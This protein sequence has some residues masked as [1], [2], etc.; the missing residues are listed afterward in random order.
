MHG[1]L[2]KLTARALICAFLIA[3]S[4]LSSAAL[5][6]RLSVDLVTDFTPVQD[7]YVVRVS[8]KRVRFNGTGPDVAEVFSERVRYVPFFEG[9]DPETSKRLGDFLYEDV[10]SPQ[11]FLVDVDLL[12]HQENIVAH[13]QM[14]VIVSDGFTVTSSI[15]RAGTSETSLRLIGDQNRDGE[16]SIGD[17]VRAEVQ[18]ALRQ[19][20]A[21]SNNEYVFEDNFDHGNVLCAGTVTADGAT[22][23]SGNGA[24]D[25][26]VRV[27]FPE[28]APNLTLI[29]YDFVVAPYLNWQAGTQFSSDKHRP[30]VKSDDPNSSVRS[31]PVIV[32]TQ[33]S[34]GPA[35]F[36]TSVVSNDETVRRGGDLRSTETGGIPRNGGLQVGEGMTPRAGSLSNVCRNSVQGNIAWDYNNQTEWAEANVENLCRGADASPEPGLCFLR[37]MHGRVS[38]G[39]TSLW[40]WQEALAL[41]RGSL[42]HNATINCFSAAIAR[43][44][45]VESATA[46][47]QRAY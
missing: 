7:F 8:A 15:L 11:E 6:L 12:D 5:P 20:A 9:H 21:G 16:I 37:A 45:S 27:I 14:E 35:C 22:V 25:N 32:Q 38:R 31:D 3:T 17:T 29:E 23:V 1:A 40:T 42:D 44:E 34:D 43:G 24:G 26:T 10:S 19:N 28:N 47:C 39:E 13:Q 33:L 36:R 46:E 41:C 2:I 18:T 30:W 4:A